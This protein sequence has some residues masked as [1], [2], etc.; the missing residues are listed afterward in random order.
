M[1]RTPEQ[2][3]VDVRFLLA[4][5]RTLLAWVRTALAIEAGGLALMQFADIHKTLGCLVLIAGAIVA[6]IG[7]NRYRAADQA[8]RQGRLPRTGVGP[9]LEV[10]MV[11]VL[12]LGLG[13]A[14]L[15]IKH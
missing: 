8:I 6:V 10:V 3:D 11:V 7:Y 4:N 12:A 1:K 14:E 9:A 15:F 5:E 2:L 13:L